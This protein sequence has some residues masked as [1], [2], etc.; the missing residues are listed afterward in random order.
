MT[1]DHLV[2]YDDAVQNFMM[3]NGVSD[4]FRGQIIQFIVSNLGPDTT[5]GEYKLF[6]RI[7]VS[8]V[9]SKIEKLSIDY[10]LEF[11]LIKRMSI[12]D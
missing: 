2:S 3:S 4:S 6:D 1:F 11:F 5:S 8:G 10:V 9:L 7:N 12:V